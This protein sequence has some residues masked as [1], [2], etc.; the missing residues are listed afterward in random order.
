M[1]GQLSPVSLN[2]LPICWRCTCVGNQTGVCI[3]WCVSRQR[4]VP[5][6]RI[7]DNRNGIVL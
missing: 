1:L 6:R 4:A 7:V 3:H 2:V 5:F